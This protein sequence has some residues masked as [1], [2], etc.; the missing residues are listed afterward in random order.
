ML[1]KG[2]VAGNDV[3]RTA[4][5]EDGG[6]FADPHGFRH[7]DEKIIQEAGIHGLAQQRADDVRRAGEDEG[8]VDRRTHT[9]AVPGRHQGGQRAADQ[10]TAEG[11]DWH[12]GQREKYGTDKLETTG[13]LLETNL[14]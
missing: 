1:L 12:K 6:R 8:S 2:I 4:R 10:Q 7:I 14:L 5:R 3:R 11:G 9:F 13:N